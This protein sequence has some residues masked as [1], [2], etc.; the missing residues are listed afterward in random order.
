M[1]GLAGLAGIAGFAALV[2]LPGKHRAK[3]GQRLCGLIFCLC[4]LAT[5]ATLPSCGGISDSGAAA[6]TYPIT[7]TGT[8]QSS[9]G[10]AVTEQ[11]SFN[12]VVR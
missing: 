2:V 9:T 12:L 7:V 10:T 6:G 1:A 8:F 3:P 5:L 4:I 11:V